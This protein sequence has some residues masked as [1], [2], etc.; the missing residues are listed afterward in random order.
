MEVSGGLHAEH[1]EEP[2]EAGN[3]FLKLPVDKVGLESILMNKISF[4][5]LP[6]KLNRVRIAVFE[7]GFLL[8]F[9][10]L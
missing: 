7:C 8:L 1:G 6:A 10:V 4:R 5:N 2:Q 9:F 3:G